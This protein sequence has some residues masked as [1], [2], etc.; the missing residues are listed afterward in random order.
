[1]NRKSNFCP[2]AVFGLLGSV[3]CIHTQAQTPAAANP[4]MYVG[5]AT[6]LP[7]ANNTLVLSSAGSCFLLGGSVTSALVGHQIQVNAVLVPQQGVQPI[8]LQVK[9]VVAVKAACSQTCTLQPPG[10]R[11]LG[12]RDK[13][14][15]EGGTPGVTSS[16]QPQP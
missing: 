4:T 5:C 11:G 9:S 6:V 1:M 2:T 13:P 10:T 14:G 16:P 15:R 7:Q 3:L 8:S 12:P